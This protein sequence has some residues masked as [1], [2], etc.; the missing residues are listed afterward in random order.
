MPAGVSVYIEVTLKRETEMK[1]KMMELVAEL[2]TM[3]GDLAIASANGEDT[4][5]LESSIM[6]TLTEYELVV[7]E[8]TEGN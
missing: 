6:N 4:S 2:M 8:L 7:D 5:S 1:S 3:T